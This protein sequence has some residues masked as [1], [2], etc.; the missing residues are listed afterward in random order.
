VGQSPSLAQSQ[1]ID[2]GRSIVTQYGMRVITNETWNTMT[3]GQAETLING[4]AGGA[5]LLQGLG[6]SNIVFVYKAIGDIPQLQM[7][8]GDGNF[9]GQTYN[10][11]IMSLNPSNGAPLHISAI[12]SNVLSPSVANPLGDAGGP[13]QFPTEAPYEPGD[14]E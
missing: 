5:N 6:R 4:G 10:S 3:L 9:S 2:I 14:D 8:G 13:S 12:P 7:I 1:L 11:I